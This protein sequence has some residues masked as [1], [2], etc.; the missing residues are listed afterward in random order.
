MKNN[1]FFN[2]IIITLIILFT[3][4]CNIDN[5]RA[6]PNVKGKAYELTIVIKKSAW[7]GVPGE[8]L[9]SIFQKEVGYLPQ[10]EAEFSV[11]NI[12]TEAFTSVFRHHR[13]VLKVDFGNYKKTGIKYEKDMWAYP[14][15]FVLIRAKNYNEFEKIFAQ[16]KEKLLNYFI[17]GE[18]TRM[19]N[20]YEKFKSNSVNKRIKE[21]YNISVTI[22]KGYSLDV[23]SANFA[24][25]SHESR[26][27]QQGIFIYTY[28]YTDTNTFTADYLVKKRNEFLQKH[29]PGPS[30]G[31]Y[32]TTEMLLPVG[33]SEYI[34]D[35][36]YYSKIKGLWKVENDFMGGP[37]ISISTVDEKQNRVITIEGF[38]YYPKKNKR[39]L[40]KQ[41]EVICESMKVCE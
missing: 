23:D 20:H 13:N 17:E 35:S 16:N 2:A 18:K 5:Q 8:L 3:V 36:T 1:Q 38:V 34:A 6:L 39:N 33:F 19:K 14:Q 9:K 30:K 10:P 28:P 22:P 25:L 32:M 31:S 12:P 41:M 21:K 26:E 37:F 40:M 7:K 27:V 4:S 15:Y 11:T 24:W 29:V